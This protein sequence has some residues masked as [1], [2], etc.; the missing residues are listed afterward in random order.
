MEKNKYVSLLGLILIVGACSDDMSYEEK[1]ELVGLA[2]GGTIGAMIGDDYG[3][4]EVMGAGFG[5]IAGA[6]LG[7]AIG[8]KLDE[9]DQLKAEVATLTALKMEE[10]TTVS[11]KSPKNENV[12]GRVSTRAVRETASVNCKSVTHVVNIRGKE[13]REKDT[14]CQQSDGSWALS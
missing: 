14:L 12:S 8:A 5:M 7:E 13:Y 3:A 6:M 4:G 10:D 2:V 11:W 1:G 9:V